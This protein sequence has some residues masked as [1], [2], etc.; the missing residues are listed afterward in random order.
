[1]AEPTAPYQRQ[2]KESSAAFHAFCQYRDLGSK[3]TLGE[4]SRLLYRAESPGIQIISNDDQGGKKKKKPKEKHAGQVGLWSRKFDWI[5]RAAAWDRLIDQRVREK[6][7][8]E[9]EKMAK[10][11]AQQAEILQQ[12]LMSPVL[13]LAR[14]LQDPMRAVSIET[15]KMGELLEMSF[16]SAKAIPRLQKAERLARGVKVVD[17]DALSSTGS[18]QGG[19]EWRVEIHQPE[20]KEPLPDL[21]QLVAPQTDE[22]EDA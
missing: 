6:Q 9:I 14:G 21:D 2:E 12:V 22:W 19:H 10:R 15:A 16:E 1:M 13:A 18:T 17:H 20:R 11:Q 4:V 7:L 3:R 5:E 8:S